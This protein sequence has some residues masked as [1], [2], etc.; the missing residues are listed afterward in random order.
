MWSAVGSSMVPDSLDRVAEFCGGIKELL[1]IIVAATLWGQKWEGV[2]VLCHCDNQAVV[3]V[4]T[5]EI[6][7]W[8]TC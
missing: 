6:R 1:P 3:G 5:A 4:D 2:S 7:Q 8:P